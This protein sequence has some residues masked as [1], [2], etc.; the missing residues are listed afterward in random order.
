[1][2]FVVTKNDFVINNIAKTCPGNFY[3][4][5][6]ISKISETNAFCEWLFE[7]ESSVRITKTDKVQ[8]LNEIMDDISESS[9]N[10]VVSRKLVCLIKYL[11]S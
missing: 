6:K 2:S 5:N 10:E 11:K 4:P 1:L 7:K 9:K 3:Q 8:R